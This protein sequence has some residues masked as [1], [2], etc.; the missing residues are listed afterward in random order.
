M[1]NSY[2]QFKQFTVQQDACAMKVTTDACLF[3]AWCAAEIQTKNSIG[4]TAL[5]IG[6]G[7]G[8]LSLM[9]AQKNVLQIDAIEI[10]KLAAAQAQSNFEASPWS[11][12][13]HIIN[14]DILEYVTQKKVD[15]IVCNPPFYQNELA[16]PDTQK[17][18]AHH[19]KALNLENLIPIMANL[20]K[21]DGSIFLLLPYK[22]EQEIEKWLKENDL[23]IYQKII[24][25][26]LTTKE[27]FRIMFKAGREKESNG[28]R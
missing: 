20:I 27:P 23:N 13:L 28:N 3:G 21:E 14:K 26:P 2:F 11:E 6:T 15:Y 4:K 18:I 17:N 25:R 24:V 1:A 5:D 8:L 7:T 9:L 10:N 16:S 19:S 22:R 12:N